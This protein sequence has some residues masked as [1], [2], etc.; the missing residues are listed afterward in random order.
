MDAA[1]S[2][3]SSSPAG[4]RA[5]GGS[6]AGIAHTVRLWRI[7]GPRLPP[8]Y[9]GLINLITPYG[10]AALLITLNSA[11]LPLPLT[12]DIVFVAYASVCVCLCATAVALRAVMQNRISPSSER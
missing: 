12:R 9:F 8:D 10:Y 11:C 6:A 4:T 7:T 2:L 3:C 5:V 1:A